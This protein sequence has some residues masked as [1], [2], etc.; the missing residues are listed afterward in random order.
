MV[1][2]SVDAMTE[3]SDEYDEI[4]GL[5]LQE[6]VFV[7]RPGRGELARRCEGLLT[8]PGRV[9]SKDRSRRL[10]LCL[11]RGGVWRVRGVTAGEMNMR[12]QKER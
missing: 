5:L 10:N 4:A 2:E 1:C 7:A 12:V 6:H 3:H 8:R 9:L 11:F